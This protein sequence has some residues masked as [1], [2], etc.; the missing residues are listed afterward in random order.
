M[1]YLSWAYYL[2]YI[3]GCASLSFV[4]DEGLIGLF[5]SFLIGKKGKIM[6]LFYSHVNL[7]KALLHMEPV[8]RSGVYEMLGVLTIKRTSASEEPGQ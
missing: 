2:S 1:V 5:S 3:D 7:L 6:S 8:G 4:L